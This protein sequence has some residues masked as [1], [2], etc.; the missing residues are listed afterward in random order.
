MGIE[1]IKHLPGDLPG[2]LW[3]WH[4]GA[5]ALASWAQGVR[6]VHDWL[7]GQGVSVRD[8]VVV[9]PQMP[10]VFLAKQVWAREVGGWMPRFETAGSLLQRLPA[11]A[12]S[13]DAA[14]MVLDETLDLLWIHQQ[15]RQSGLG[16]QWL[17]DAPAHAQLAS[18]RAMALAH[19]WLKICLGLAPSRRTAWVDQTL[20]WCVQQRIH[21]PASQWQPSDL[22]DVGARERWLTGQALDWAMQSWPALAHRHQPLFECEA[23]AWV[24]V[25]VG[26]AVVPGSDAF[27]M[28]QVLRE[29]K[30]RHV[31]VCWMPACWSGE[32]PG[33]V[34]DS[35]DRQQVVSPLPTLTAAQHF[36][37]EAQAAASWVIAAVHQ[38]RMDGVRDP[39]V[40]VTQDRVLSRR[41]R[42]LLMPHEGKAGLVI[43]DESGWTLS[44][45]RAA[46]AVTRLLAAAQ[47][48]ADT[49]AVLDWL[50]HGWAQL[51]FEQ[52]ALQA[53]KATEVSW[54][55]HKVIHPWQHDEGDEKA[56]AAWPWARQLLAPLASLASSSVTLAEALGRLKL[57]L[58]GAGVW[59][60]LMQDQAGQLVLK[61]L[62]LADVPADEGGDAG[63]FSARQWELLSR[64]Y[65]VNLS[66]LT[67]WVQQCLGRVN[68][69]PQVQTAESADVGHIQEIDVVMTPMGRA[70][71]RPF[72]GVVMP[73]VDEN[74]LGV[75]PPAGHL[76]GSS[77]A[78][79]GLPEPQLRWQSQW[80]AFALLAAQPQ[81]RAVYRQ[82][83]D[84]GPLAPSAWLGRWWALAQP[85]TWHD[86][87]WPLVP[88][89]RPEQAL[90]M[91]PL[92]PVLPCLDSCEHEPDL[93]FSDRLSPSAYQRLRDC[94]YRYF[95]LDL[96]RLREPDEHDEGMAQQDYGNWLHEVLRRFHSP[97]LEGRRRWP[98]EED[99]PQWLKLAEEVALEQGLHA[100][101]KAAHLALYQ[102]SLAVLAEKYVAWHHQQ[103]A[104]GWHARHL[105]QQVSVCWAQPAGAEPDAPEAWQLT[106]Y[107]KL[108]RVDAKGSGASIR[109]ID[110]KTG[111]LTTLNDRVKKPLEDTQL[112]FYALLLSMQAQA[113]RRDVSARETPGNALEAMYLHLSNEKVQAVNHTQVVFSADQLA[114]GICSDMARIR[115]G[116]PMP[117]LGEGALCDRCEVRGLC[118][119]DHQASVAQETT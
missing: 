15:L 2:V 26:T 68:F 36:N 97:E 108:D 63:Y 37:D 55:Q 64:Q 38:R 46:A 75:M 11:P 17:R 115:Q 29:A 119:K 35:T 47:P 106:L 99:L 90:D 103:Q 24:L 42:A 23:S 76:L 40:L 117:A 49:W 28:Q 74:Q 100:T 66:G 50:T 92:E 12:V 81:V 57:A 18:A 94:P 88:D 41:I 85:A 58:Q 9:V 60:A 80:A 34:A 78:A 8:A 84:G 67:D 16:R 71:L 4:T 79:L 53:L 107:G 87:H 33:D 6:L 96:L 91:Q 39:V 86:Q 10:H 22:S 83:H 118:R 89:P 61:S 109:V 7:Q 19:E 112:A 114:Q 20:A 105:E 48:M 25:T 111:S 72:A 104:A 45:T 52:G 82:S 44:T 56:F 73:G 59:Q 30:S 51:P 116:H 62:R 27:T 5:T 98:P 32:W 13:A 21:Q 113:S 102:S 65:A 101:R 110:Y 31:P 69:E 95:A 77:E 1:K 93:L 3:R 43:Q 14:G 70:V 54:R